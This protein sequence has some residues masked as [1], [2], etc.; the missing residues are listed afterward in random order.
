MLKALYACEA[1]V[2]KI[3]QSELTKRKRGPFF[4]LLYVVVLAA[5]FS[6]PSYEEGF[7]WVGFLIVFGV[8]AVLAVGANALGAKRFLSFAKSHHIEITEDG[9]ESKGLDT[10]ETLPWSSV[11]RVKKSS[12]NG[13]ITKLILKTANSGSIDL[14]KYEQL[15]SIATNLKLHIKNE[16]W[17]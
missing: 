9:L 13:V 12:K 3:K 7:D 6:L 1:A 4:V 17:Q 2:Y 15:D 14:S 10:Y 8:T 16:L 5:I 11:T